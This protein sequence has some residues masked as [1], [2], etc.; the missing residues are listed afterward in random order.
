MERLDRE[1]AAARTR[2][3]GVMLNEKEEERIREVERGGQA[4]RGRGGLILKRRARRRGRRGGRWRSYW[5]GM[6]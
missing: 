1:S 3:A 4:E 5:L 2:S 6:K